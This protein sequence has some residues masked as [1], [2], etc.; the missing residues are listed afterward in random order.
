MTTELQRA[1]MQGLLV[2]AFAHLPCAAYRLLRITEAGPARQWLAGAAAAVTTAERKQE[3]SSLNIALTGEGLKELGLPTEVLRTFPPAF[4]DGMTSPR[5]SRLLGDTGQ[6]RPERWDWGGPASPAHVLLLLYAEDE[7][8]LIREQQRW[9]P[10]DGRGLA[11]V[12][13]LEAGRQPDAREHFGFMDGVGQPVVEGSGRLA[14][15]RRRTGHATELPT[16]EFVLGYRNEYGIPSPTPTVAAA[17]DPGAVL[18]DARTTTGRRDLGLNGSYLVF[19]QISQNVAAFWRFAE[20]A[21]AATWPDDPA[22]A[23]RLASK[24]VGRWPSGS[25]LVLHPRVDGGKLENDFAYAAAD[26]HGLACPLGAHIRRANPRDALGPDP[27]T[28]LASARRH[29]LLRRGRSYGKRLEDRLRD[30]GAARGLHFI[31]LNADLERQFEF[32]QQTW[33]NNPVFAGLYHE[34]DPL[35]GDQS[36]T[37][38]FT[39]QADPLRLRVPGLGAFTQIRGGGYFFLPGIRAL[40][41]LFS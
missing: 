28:A 20:E 11:E 19:R 27:K 23:T 15:Q 1:D 36:R 7:Q 41:F 12:T 39:I 22:G 33:I 18:P 30:D 31:C 14:R 32:V 25:P 10:G 4:L 37:G 13:T 16:G 17:A 5:R 34:T 40:R 6:N 24:L 3:G 26:P 35:V 38:M 8:R 2:S 21:A 29:R 9:T